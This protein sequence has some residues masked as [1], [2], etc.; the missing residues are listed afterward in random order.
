MALS[1]ADSRSEPASSAHA[2]LDAQEEDDVARAKRLSLQPGQASSAAEALSFKL[3]DAEW[4]TPACL[5]CPT[6]PALMLPQQWEGWSLG[7]DNQKVGSGAAIPVEPACFRLLPAY[8]PQLHSSG[9]HGQ[10]NQHACWGPVELDLHSLAVGVKAPSLPNPF[11]ATCCS[12][13]YDDVVCDGLYDLWGSFPELQT[14]NEAPAGGAHGPSHHF[15]SLQALRNITFWEG[16]AREVCLCIGSSQ[17]PKLPPVLQV[18][19]V[20]QGAR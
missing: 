10:S 20:M 15:P 14:P 19:V 11:C 8:N 4:C 6:C 12:L 13:N 18:I 1:Q 3:W 17:H 16:D 5:L 7:M 9:V 2:E